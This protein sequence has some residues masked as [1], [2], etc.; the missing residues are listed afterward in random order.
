MFR[1]KCIPFSWQSYDVSGERRTRT[2]NMISVIRIYLLLANSSN[3]SGPG[4]T[5]YHA[6]KTSTERKYSE[7]KNKSCNIMSQIIATSKGKDQNTHFR[8][9]LSLIFNSC[10]ACMFWFSRMSNIRDIH[11][12]EM[13][14]FPK[15]YGRQRHRCPKT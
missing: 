11:Q 8:S 12:E 1:E 5:I 7:T 6:R 13:K 10:H 15:P 3:Q 14:D 2:N 9:G 4:V